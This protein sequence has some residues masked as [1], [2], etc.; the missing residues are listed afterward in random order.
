M[1]EARAEAVEIMKLNPQFSL[2]A[3]LFK[4]VNP[5]DGLL[6]DLRKAGLK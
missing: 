3:G 1:K 4:A 5:Q 6:S 2:E